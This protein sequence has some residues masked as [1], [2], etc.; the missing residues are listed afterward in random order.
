MA[1]SRIAQDSKLEYNQ[2]L[3]ADLTHKIYNAMSEIVV[4][5]AESFIQEDFE[6]VILR[7]EVDSYQQIFHNNFSSVHRVWGQDG[8]NN[9]LFLDCDTLVTGPTAVFG[10]YSH[11]QMFNYTDP[12]FVDGADKD[13]KYG[14]D[15]DHYFNAGCRYY[16]ATMK[17][18]VWDLGWKYASDWDYNIWGTEQLIF[19]AMQYSQDPDVNTWLI[20][21]MNY[22]AM[23]VPYNDITNARRIDFLN[24]WNGVDLNDA[25]IMHLHGTRGASNT[26]LL[27]WEL[28]RMIT[29]EE[30]EFTEFIVQQDAQG[31]AVGLYAKQQ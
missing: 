13:N 25:K 20:P 29:G 22:Q 17:Q 8:P 14:L 4:H 21:E 12:K 5:S 16:P 19:N 2:N 9:V 6:V 30:F 31:K 15:F 3:G 11:F 24:K 28:W 27:Q 10:Q 7:D 1:V 18:P 26:L 23:N